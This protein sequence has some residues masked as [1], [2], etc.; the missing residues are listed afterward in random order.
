MSQFDLEAYYKEQAFTLESAYTDKYQISAIYYVLKRFID[1]ILSIVGLIVG[2]PLMLF[3]ALLIILESPG[4]PL[5]SQERVG[6]DGKI[7]TLYKL[8]SM[9]LNAEING[10]QWADKEDPRVTKVGKLIRK[11]R[12]DEIPQ[13]F[14]VLKGHMS[15][16]GPRPERPNF[17]IQFNE[18]IPGFINR[19]L[20]MPGLT[21][22]AQVN[23]G[24][25]MSP[26]EK[27]EYDMEYIQKKS[28]KLDLL[29][30][31]KTFRVLF[32]GEGAR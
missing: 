2:I 18:E 24:Y 19:T 22:W 4:S 23:G 17:T 14:N 30:I 13:I 26:K 1:I 20:V 12:I 32:T 15:V 11:T 16:V 27:L 10:E 8:R 9:K 3:F 25:D 7:F 31:L 29:I 6:K 5:Y 21:G 28:I